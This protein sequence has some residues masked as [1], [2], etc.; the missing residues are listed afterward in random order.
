MSPCSTPPGRSATPAASALVERSEAPV[1]VRGQCFG[2][3][4]E[5]RIRAVLTSGEAI[6]LSEEP[7]TLLFADPQGAVE[8]ANELGVGPVE[9]ELRTSVART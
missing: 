3:T 1:D 7:L 5:G 6:D 8:L 9:D 4:P 2:G